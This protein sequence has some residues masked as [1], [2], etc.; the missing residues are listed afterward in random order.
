MKKDENKQ[1][2]YDERASEQVSQQIMDSYTSG[3]VGTEDGRYDAEEK[4]EN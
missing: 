2:T 3:V 1:L 4:K